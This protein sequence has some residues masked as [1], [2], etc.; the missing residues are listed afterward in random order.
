MTLKILYPT[1]FFLYLIKN[2]VMFKKY[3]YF[4]FLIYKLK[5]YKNKYLRM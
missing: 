3:S 4:F 1:D 2:N 5:Y